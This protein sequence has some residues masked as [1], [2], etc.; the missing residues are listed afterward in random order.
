M[1]NL[2]L[3]S[4]VQGPRGLPIGLI[5]QFKERH[6]EVYEV[7]HL[8]DDRELLHNH[9]SNIYLGEALTEAYILHFQTIQQMQ[10][11][12]TAIDVRQVD[13]SAV[14]FQSHTSEGVFF[15]VDWSVGGIVTHQ[16]HKHTRVNRYQAGY[17]LQQDEN[18]LWKI[19]HTRVRNAERVQRAFLSDDAF[20]NGDDAGGGYLDPLDLLEGGLL[21]DA[22]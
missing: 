3:F 19:A 9:L 20:F 12:E 1:I 2:L 18:G 21:E 11:D 4:C 14:E 16:K 17:T 13:Y 22:P 15:D 8:G 7:Y 5:E 6:A 10:R